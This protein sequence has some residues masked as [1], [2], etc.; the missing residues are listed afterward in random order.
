MQGLQFANGETTGTERDGY[1]VSRGNFQHIGPLGWNETGAGRPLSDHHPVKFET[2]DG[3]IVT[4]NIGGTTLPGPGQSKPDVLAVDSSPALNSAFLQVR[5]VPTEQLFGKLVPKVDRHNV[6]TAVAFFG[7]TM[8]EWNT[9]TRAVSQMLQGNNHPHQL[10]LKL[11]ELLK[12]HVPIV[13][14][15]IAVADMVQIG[16]P[17]TDWQLHHSLPNKVPTSNKVKCDDVEQQ[18]ANL[19][20]YFFYMATVATMCLEDFEKS[21]LSA[22]EPPSQ[23]EIVSY[24]ESNFLGGRDEAAMAVCLQEV[25]DSMRPQLMAVAAKRGYD[26]GGQV[27]C[28]RPGAFILVQRA[29]LFTIG[30]GYL[31][32]HRA[33]GAVVT[34]P[35]VL[36]SLHGDTN[37]ITETACTHLR[38]RCNELNQ[39]HG[40]E[41]NSICVAGDFQIAKHGR[42]LEGVK[43]DVDEYFG[44]E[45]IM[46]PPMATRMSSPQSWFCPQNK[47]TP[48]VGANA[49]P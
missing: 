11:V 42:G 48:R 6:A 5:N 18:R 31:G 36:M 43:H 27:E 22:P 33:V 38:L 8:K 17:A 12:G 32:S 15:A 10:L 39:D 41:I 44:C 45:G 3:I 7:T 2:D 1:W 49:A 13:D 29:H 35:M 14:A 47:N 9:Q 34:G 23:E 28:G 40:L 24:I 20:C 4:W 21:L 30:I 26:G 19:A 16:T 37:G 25:P 46:S